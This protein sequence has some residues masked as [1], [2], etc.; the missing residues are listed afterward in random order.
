MPL[1]VLDPRTGTRVVILSTSETTGQRRA[2]SWLLRELDRLADE[3]GRASGAL[4][5]SGR[6]FLPRT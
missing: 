3:R 4:S 2:R 6:A 5:R 1:T